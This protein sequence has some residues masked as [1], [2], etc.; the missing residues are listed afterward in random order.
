MKTSIYHWEGGELESSSL[1]K[2]FAKSEVSL[3][4]LMS[5]VCSALSWKCNKNVPKMPGCPSHHTHMPRF[6]RRPPISSPTNYPEKTM[7]VHAKVSFMCQIKSTAEISAQA[8][9]PGHGTKPRCGT[10]NLK[11]LLYLWQSWLCYRQFCWCVSQG[12]LNAKVSKNTTG[13][14]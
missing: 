4:G 2:S 3:G 12:F 6:R 7:W 9:I 8:W 1:Q 10:E 11:S 14:S 13:S 5:T